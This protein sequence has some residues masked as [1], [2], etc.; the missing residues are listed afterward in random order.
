MTE[1]KWTDAQE[2]VIGRPAGGL[3]VT[4]GAGSGKTSSLVERVAR[5]VLVG[6]IDI[7]R[8]LVVTFT[9][10]AA[11]EMRGRIRNRLQAALQTEGRRDV[12]QQL[13]RMERATISTIDS[14]CMQIVRKS[15]LHGAIA[16]G[17]AIADEASLAALARLAMDDALDGLYNAADELFLDYARAYSNPGGDAALREQARSVYAFVRARPDMLTWFDDM[18]GRLERDA[19]SPGEQMSCFQALCGHVAHQLGVALDALA[20]AY[21]VAMDAGAA[22]VAAHLQQEVEWLSGASAAA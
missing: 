10:A 17:F 20:A 19:D 2:R 11:Q 7:D 18:V 13:H 21:I 12:L 16:P 15:A 3:I 4:A 9:E 14:F 1:R 8:I 22:K 5:R 6:G